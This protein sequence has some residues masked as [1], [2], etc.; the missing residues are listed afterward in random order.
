MLLHNHEVICVSL[1]W[2]QIPRC[3]VFVT[4]IHQICI[5]KCGKTLSNWNAVNWDFV[6]PFFISDILFE[7]H[8]KCY[9]LSCHTLLFKLFNYKVLHHCKEFIM[10]VFSNHPLWHVGICCCLVLWWEEKRCTTNSFITCPSYFHFYNCS[11]IK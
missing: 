2:C 4:G 9:I 1:Y 7:H 5:V 10:L 6:T 8:H 11:L 3:R